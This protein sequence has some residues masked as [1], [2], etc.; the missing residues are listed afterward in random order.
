MSAPD[1]RPAVSVI[2]PFVG[3]D[4][5]QAQLLG[6]LDALVLGPDDELIIADNRRDPVRTPAFARNRG[7]REARGEWLVFLDADAEPAPELIDAYLQPLPAERTAV[8]AGAVR[9]VAPGGGIVAR[10][11]VARAHLSQQTTLQRRQ[12]PYAQTVNCAV[13]RQAFQE[14][15]GFAET[16]RAGEDADLCFRLQLTGWGIE[17][18]PG[19]LARHRGRETIR[20]WVEQL[21]VHGSGAAW[22]NRN[23]PGE[24]PPPSVVGFAARL[25]RYA[26][27]ALRAAGRGDREA[28]S[29]ALLDALGACAFELG[30]LL[31]NA[32]RA[33]RQSHLRGFSR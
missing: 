1:S 3:S 30:R 24:F 15:G 25:A 32:R 22:V 20:A 23:W 8:L 21:A 7:A 14:V 19:A 26:A 12:L 4:A 2:V 16:A 27:I 10:H 33:H 17:S 11:A 6:A 9:D 18:R 5:E 13:R 28:A 29:F 31:P